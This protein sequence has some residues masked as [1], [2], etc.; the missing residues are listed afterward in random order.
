MK[1]HEGS[2]AVP[3]SVGSPKSVQAASAVDVAAIASLRQ[4]MDDDRAVCS[5]V[6]SFLELLPGRVQAIGDSARK[7]EAA[8]VL[9]CSRSIGVAAEMAGAPRL[10]RIAEE[11]V[12]LVQVGGLPCESRIV[13]LRVEAS[14]SAGELHS[15]LRELSLAC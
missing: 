2:E 13:A 15:Y 5:F 14:R 3:K 4:Q 1:H 6:E 11:I 8:T 7:G 9:K 10:A 12:A